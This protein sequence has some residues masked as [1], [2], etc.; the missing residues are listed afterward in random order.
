M[1]TLPK[2]P[3]HSL[4]LPGVRS[5]PKIPWEWG[6]VGL[7]RGTSLQLCPTFSPCNAPLRPTR[8]A[9]LPQHP[10]GSPQHPGTRHSLGLGAAASHRRQQGLAAAASGGSW[11]LSQEGM[12]LLRSAGRARSGA[13]SPGRDEAR[14]SLSEKASDLGSETPRAREPTALPV[15]G[16]SRHWVVLKLT[17]KIV[18]SDDGRYQLRL[19]RLMAK[20]TG[21]VCD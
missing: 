15:R 9:Q 19:I 10:L 4:H 11:F 18:I 16:N 7:W 20:S 21:S 14:Q 13:G 5:C 2:S 6:V 3:A 12:D 17:M 1:P 8:A